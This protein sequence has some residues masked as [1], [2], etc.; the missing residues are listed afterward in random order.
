M[1]P[2]VASP[3]ARLMSRSARREKLMLPSPRPGTMVANV[4]ICSP[5]VNSGSPMDS[6]SLKCSAARRYAVLVVGHQLGP[7]Q[8]GHADGQRAFVAGLLAQFAQV[9]S[10]PSPPRCPRPEMSSRTEWFAGRFASP[11]DRAWTPAFGRRRREPCSSWNARPRCRGPPRACPHM[12]AVCFEIACSVDVG[13]QRSV[14]F[15]DPGWRRCIAAATRR[16]SS[17]RSDFSCA[18]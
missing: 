8:S 7:H 17:A 15:A 1:F 11:V 5:T 3:S 10:I 14:L 2:L 4:A 9:S 12:P 16:W 18:L 6:S 13:D